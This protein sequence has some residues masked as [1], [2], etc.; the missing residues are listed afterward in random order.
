MEKKAKHYLKSKTLGVATLNVVIL[1]FVPGS[2]EWIAEHPEAYVL[3][4]SFTMA[5]LRAVTEGGL[6]WKRK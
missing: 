1:E 3:I 4:L 2:A 5:G 6:T